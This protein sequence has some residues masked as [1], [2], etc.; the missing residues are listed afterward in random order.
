MTGE[1]TWP[2]RQN[3]LDETAD[4]LEQV[5]R[6][7]RARDAAPP[8]DSAIDNRLIAAGEHYRRCRMRRESLF[9]DGDAADPAWDILIDLY[10]KARA[11]RD[12]SVSSASIASLAAPTTALRWISRLC[13]VGL[14]VREK[15]EGDRRRSLVRLT[16]EGEAKAR[17]WLACL[18]G[19]RAGEL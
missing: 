14:V 1:L 18:A 5:L 2:P 6:K 11:E 9:G 8:I 10:L 12:V 15:D 17:D 16:V 3:A 4:E 7:L 19:V 13:E